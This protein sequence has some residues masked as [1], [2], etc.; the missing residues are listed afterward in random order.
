[1]NIQNNEH[2]NEGGLITEMN[3]TPLIDVFLV[4]LIIFMVT[5]SMLSQ[6]GIDIKLPRSSQAQPVS[7]S[8]DGIWVTLFPK[9]QIH[10]NRKEVIGYENFEKVLKD[11]FLKTKTRLVIL[12]GDQQAFLGSIIELMDHARKAG[13]DRFAIATRKE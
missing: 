10:V 6:V 4:L 2:E 11:S 8:N 9:G 1:M 12:E 5:S 3:M 13:A 7:S